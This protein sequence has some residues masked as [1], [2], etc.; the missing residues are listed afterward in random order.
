MFSAVGALYGAQLFLQDLRLPNVASVLS[1]HEAW[2]DICRGTISALGRW[3]RRHT[4]LPNP[5]IS[6]KVAFDFFRHT[7]GTTHSEI[8]SE[9]GHR[10]PERFF[11]FSI[12]GWLV[13]NSIVGRPTWNIGYKPEDGMVTHC[14]VHYD[15]CPGVCL[16]LTDGSC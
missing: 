4:F 12:N 11:V 7:D 9:V 5:A 2:S 10:R 15:T 14:V 1:T 8:L 3:R 6:W 13:Q 16:N